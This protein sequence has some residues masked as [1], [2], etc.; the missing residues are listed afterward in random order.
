MEYV[1]VAVKLSFKRHQ[2]V[3]KTVK[4]TQN[5]FKLICRSSSIEIFNRDGLLPLYFNIELPEPFAW[6][7]NT[8]GQYYCEP[9]L[10]IEVY[11]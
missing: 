5:C 10:E 9:D 7:K 3:C 8:T 1:V 2:T 4:M 6:G 11:L